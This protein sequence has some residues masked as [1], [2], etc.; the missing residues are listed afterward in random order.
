MALTSHFQGKAQQLPHIAPFRQLSR[1]VSAV[2]AMNPSPFALTGTNTYLVGT[3]PRRILVDTGEG[4]AEY[5]PLLEDAMK[6][7]GVKGLQEIVITHWHFDH[8]GGL[9]SVIERFGEVPVRKY[10][11]DEI[12]PLFGGEGSV[13]PYQ[14]WPREKFTPLQD[15]E[16]LKTEGAT[17]KVLYTPGHAN[18]HVVLLHQEEKAMFTADNVLGVGTAVFRDLTEYMNSLERMKKAVVEEK[19]E[20]LYPAHGPVLTEPTNILEGYIAH[21]QERI[22]QIFN[23]LSLDGRTA[24]QLARRLYEGVPDNLI[25][26]ATVNTTQALLKLEHDGRA[27]RSSRTS[28]PMEA[29][30]TLPQLSSS[31]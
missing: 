16:I 2:L 12:E 27:L 24:E 17:L 9:P 31:L 18:D 25:A 19:I 26:A 30:W 28:N 15:E 6:R 23:L 22:E 11:P 5:L 14:I 3:G 4:K 10:M 29:S 7:L 13:D 20:K 1:S 21:R 8:L